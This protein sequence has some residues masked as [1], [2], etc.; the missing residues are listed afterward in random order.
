[1]TTVPARRERAYN[2]LRPII[3]AR[4]RNEA[5]HSQDWE[6]RPVRAFTVQPMQR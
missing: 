1:M 4:L 2:H 6:G 5:E 3:Q